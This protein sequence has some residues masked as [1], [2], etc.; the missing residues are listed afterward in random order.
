M[1]ASRRS[2]ERLVSWRGGSGYLSGWR[3]RKAAMKV[4]CPLRVPCWHPL[5]AC[6]LWLHDLRRQIATEEGGD[7]GGDTF[8]RADER[9][10]HADRQ[11][12]GLSA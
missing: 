2:T 7:S 8:E 4:R 5:V 12:S 9:E 6:Q 10:P 11:D 3:P 1:T